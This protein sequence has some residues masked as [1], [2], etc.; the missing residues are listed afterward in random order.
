MSLV[1]IAGHRIN[2]EIFQ[3]A[4]VMSST[5]RAPIVL[6]HEGLGSVAGWGPFPVQLAESTQRTVIAYDRR[7]YGRSDPFPGPWPPT[8]LVDEAH[9][10]LTPLIAAVAA[11]PPI[12]VGHSD[13]ASAALALPAHRG[14]SGLAP[15]GIVAIAPHVFVEDVSITAIGALLRNPERVIK[16]LDRHQPDPSGLLRNWSEVWTSPDMA[17]WN[18]DHELESIDCPVLVI[19]GSRDR[20]GTSAQLERM[21]AHMTDSLDTVELPDVDHWP[22]RECTDHVL[23]MVATFCERVDPAHT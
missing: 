12:L 22:H 17:N 10:I 11:E 7:G 14:D 15:L 1:T 2:V 18:L 6:L 8:F 16:S 20:Y 5:G 3:P 13:G 23:T 19:Q 21:A 4:E 9:A